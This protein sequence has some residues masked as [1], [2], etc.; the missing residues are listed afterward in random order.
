MENV[1]LKRVEELN[2]IPDDPRRQEATGTPSQVAEWV[3]GWQPVSYE[4]AGDDE[5]GNCSKLEGLHKQSGLSGTYQLIP[6]ASEPGVHKD[7][8]HHAPETH[9]VDEHMFMSLLR[10]ALSTLDE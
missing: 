2:A 9:G 10:E 3:G 7:D 5:K 4:E 8:R 6:P 1:S